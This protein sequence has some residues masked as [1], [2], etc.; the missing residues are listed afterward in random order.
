MGGEHQNSVSAFIGRLGRSFERIMFKAI[1]AW[2]FVLTFLLWIV[3]TVG[4]G[5]VVKHK[6]ESQRT[7]GVVGDAAFFVA[8]FPSL[9]REALS[10]V[11]SSMPL[12]RGDPFPGQAG[13]DVRG[14]FID[15][16]YLLMS[17]HD[18]DVGATSVKLIRLSDRKQIYRWIVNLD[19]IRKHGPFKSGW[20][21]HDNRFRAIHPLMVADGGVMFHDEQGPLVKLNACSNVE[22]IYDAPTHHEIDIGPAGNIW[23]ASAVQKVNFPEDVYPGM[24][25]DAI[26]EVSPSGERMMERSVAGILMRNGYRGLL[27][28]VREYEAD[29]I[30]LN[31]I[32]VA[33]TDSA[34]WKAGD[35]L[36]SVRNISSVFLYRP[37]TDKVIWLKTGPWLNQHDARFLNNESISIFGN[38]VMRRSSVHE[39]PVIL[40]GH[41]EVYVYNFRTDT[42]SAPYHKILSELKPVTITEGRAKILPDGDLFF[43][44]TDFGRMFRVSDRDIRWTYVDRQDKNDP[45][46]VANWSRYLSADAVEPSLSKLHCAKRS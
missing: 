31:S 40:G 18:A 30:H 2:L 7:F 29:I 37:G 13:F 24:K 23:T 27:F 8:S 11:S 20:E 3:G 44:E 43:E 32:E 34:Y 26:T 36:V 14:G 1:P 22:W 25:D 21:P 5:W 35:I 33:R 10:D 17:S 46:G 38:D 6:M 41:N 19:E 45:I 16:G 39:S 42:V 4:F 15:K 28:G 9:V 12:V